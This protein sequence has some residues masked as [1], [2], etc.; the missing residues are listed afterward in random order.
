[1]RI[2]KTL[3]TAVIAS[4]VLLSVTAAGAS[5]A[6]DDAAKAHNDG[7]SAA[8]QVQKALQRDLGLSADEARKVLSRQ[9]DAI[10]LDKK[11]QAELGSAFAGSVFDPASG[12]LTV[13]V[14]KRSE[15]ETVRSAGAEAKF[16][17]HSRGELNKIKAELDAAAG[18]AKGAS[19]QVRKVN[20]ARKAAVAGLRGWYVDSASNTLRVTAVK[21]KLDKAKA[22]LAKYG[23]AV[24]VVEETAAAVPTGQFVDGGDGYNGNNCSVG[25]NL[26][27]KS[28]GQGY[29]LTA[30]HCVSRG[31]TVY[32]FDWTKFGLV[33]ESWF[34]G[35]D[36]ALV[37]NDNAGYWYQGA[38][39]DTNPSLGGFVSVAGYTDGPVGTTICKSGIKTKWTCGQI[40]AKNQTV[41]YSGTST[42]YGLTRHSACVE[43]G[44]SGGANVSVT[45]D[46]GTWSYKYAAE[47]VTSG[48]QLWSS[49]GALRC[50]QA[51]G[52][53]NV[54]WYFPIADSL[55]FYGPKYG[56][57][58]W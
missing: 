21:G 40:T 14:S 23:D 51:V 29:M 50:G 44:D 41:T 3:M 36:D 46:W 42:V 1:M 12:K 28:T 24:S 13:L 38:W 52:Q 7:D 56:V 58:V 27:N 9:A 16:A 15:M 6:S 53:P 37:R 55:A 34:P 39:V 47:G 33:L 45:F 20:G 35:Y 8:A 54:S 17:G 31:S 4:A 2:K 11:L 49:G 22:S 48:A 10:A 18:R 57:S 30:G 43:K 26:R 25:F 5:G 19:A 32:G